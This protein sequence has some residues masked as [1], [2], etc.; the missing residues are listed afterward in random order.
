MI[1]LL[2]PVAFV[3]HCDSA[4][5]HD[6]DRF[7]GVDLNYIRDRDSNRPGARP[8][9]KALR[10][11]GARWLRFPGGE[12]SNYHLWSKPPFSKPVPE[13]LGW[14]ATPKGDRMDFDEYIRHVRAV[15]AEPYVVVGYDSTERTG[16]TEQ[17]W[18]ETAAA[19]VRY[20]KA[21]HYAVRYWEIGNENWAKRSIS[22]R[23]MAGIV[24]E[25][26]KAMKS[27]DPSILV[28][29]SGENDNYW[30]D[31]LPIAAPA[32]DFLTVS[33]YTGW[34][35]GSYER[36]N[37]NPEMVDTAR[38]AVDAID[39]YAPP[40]D[41]T[42]LR[43]I[44][45]EANAKDYSKNGWP[46]A[47]DLGH[48][49]VTF[50]TLGRLVNLPKVEAAMV[51]TTRW[52]NDAEAPQSQFYALGPNNELMPTGEAIRAWGAFIQPVLLS[53]EGGDAT[54]EAYA[55]RSEDGASLTVWVV[56]RS[57]LRTSARL[58]L[59]GPTYRSTSLARF[60][61]NAPA[62][63]S[64]HWT[65]GP[66]PKVHGNEVDVDL[67]PWSITAIRFVRRS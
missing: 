56:N 35:W 34:E 62:D 40:D 47:N 50:S 37:D 45:A 16:L 15:G 9:D 10:E 42:R 52:M 44:V 17:Q 33:Q 4:I 21:K 54:N 27:A 13:S 41:K 14:Y 23:Q 3:V 19:W 46:D 38:Q 22:P 1:C 28:G 12:K 26:S 32:L 66:T 48:A 31:F 25:F 18:I 36:V 43:V 63:H 29:A 7:F 5:R 57:A 30:R 53:T 6:A 59:D 61:G 11:I 67:E 58:S 39:R 20:S 24:V 49:L 60:T 64:P 65:N 51:W 55:A 8:L 2:A